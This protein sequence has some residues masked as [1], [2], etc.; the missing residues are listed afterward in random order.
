MGSLA[1]RTLATSG[2]LVAGSSSIAVHRLRAGLC[3]AAGTAVAASP[4]RAVRRATLTSRGRASS[5]CSC[6]AGTTR[7]ITRGG[8]VGRAPAPPA[9]VTT[10]LW[11][12]TVATRLFA[13]RCLGSTSPRG[14]GFTAGAVVQ[15]LR[16]GPTCAC[17]ILEVCA[18]CLGG[19]GVPRG[20]AILRAPQGRV[21]VFG[22][23]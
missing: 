4:G 18:S 16:V 12:P 22:P 1:C 3:A 21:G 10:A 6:S 14:S 11:S 15:A 23:T 9:V 8:G 17:L 20:G 2:G 13:R 5:G 7:V 19:E